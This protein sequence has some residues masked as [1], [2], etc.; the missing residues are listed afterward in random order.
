MIAKTKPGALPERWE[1]GTI[2]SIAEI[3]PKCDTHQLQD[4]TPVSF[5]PM[6]NV[7]EDGR[8]ISKDWKK[9]SEVKSGFTCFQDGDVLFAKITPCMENGKGALVCGLINKIGFGSTEFF[10][11]RPKNPES[12]EF[13]YQLSR[14]P[15]IRHRASSF[16][17]G[18]AGQQRVSKSI[19]DLVRI[20]IPPLPEQ[21]RIATILSTVDDAIQ[22]SQQAIAETERLKAG[23][24]QELMTKGIGHTEFKEDPDVGRIPKEWEV[25]SIGELCDFFDHLRIPV[26]SYDR[27]KKTGKYPYYGA[28]GIIDWVDDFLFDGIFL[29]IAEDGANLKTKSLPI[30]FRASGKFWVNNHAHI[31]QPKNAILIDYLMHILNFVDIEGFVSGSAQPKLTQ[32]SLQK[33]KVPKPSVKEQKVIIT[34]LTAIDHKLTLQRQRTALLEQLKQGLMNDLLTG[35]RRVKVT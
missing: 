5:I 32:E 8:I 2:S 20:P 4:E 19:F 12:T 31:V 25:N 14:S 21:R 17:T 7:S 16:M 30:A 24:T 35:K 18:T 6:Q 28:Q 13:L 15:M 10:V 33:I 34:I 11:L 26:K 23:V 27:A 29:L 22:R 9:Y 1:F 3:N